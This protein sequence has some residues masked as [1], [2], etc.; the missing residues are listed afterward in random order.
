MPMQGYGDD[1]PR[2][3]FTLIEVVV[4][5]GV[6]A[7]L[8]AL[9][10][11]AVQS[12]REAA[13]RAQ[14]ASNLKQIGLGLAQYE[15]TAGCLPPGRIKTFDPRYAGTNPPCTSTLIDKSYEVGILPFV[16]QA[17]LYNAINQNLAVV[18][19]ENSTTHT[20]VVA[21]YACPSDSTAGTPRDL[22]AN[23]LGRYGLADPPGGRQQMVFTSYAAC[24]GSFEVIALPLVSNRCQPDPLAQQQNNGCF[25]DLSPITLAAITDGLSQT[26]F[27]VERATSPLQGV[28]AFRPDQFARHGWYITGN[29][30]DTLATT[31]YPPNACRRVTLAAPAAQFSA[32]SSLHPGGLNAL[33]GDG[34]VH[35]IRESIESWPFSPI[36]GNPT[37]ATQTR[38]GPWANLP[39]PGVWQALAT[40]AGA[41]NPALAGF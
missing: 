18:G 31:F 13:R 12:A 27:V 19:R 6:I 26:L 8:I 38:L 14:C 40:R 10:L 11:P 4:V 17:T 41:E 30:G 22:P 28:D 15:A 34:S 37:G 35:F 7:L 21:I 36:T 3:G 39:T 2:A 25:H 20:A 32:G 5:V 16:E 23:A 33:L 24:T 9:T 1:N 29:W